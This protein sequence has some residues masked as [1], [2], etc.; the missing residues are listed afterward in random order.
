M[1][2]QQRYRVV[3]LLERV[4]WSS[5]SAGLGTLVAGPLFDIDAVAAAGVAAAAG[6]I[7]AVLVI[8]RWRLAVLPDPGDGFTRH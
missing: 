4:L 1:T 3:D 5:V 8:A 6:A 2:A 7:N